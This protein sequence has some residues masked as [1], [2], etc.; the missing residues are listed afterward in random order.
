MTKRKIPIDSLSESTHPSSQAEWDST[1]NAHDRFKGLLASSP[2]AMA[3]YNTATAEIEARMVTL[4]NLRKAQSLTQ[5][6][7]AELL[8]MDQSEV[9]RLENRTD[10]LL[11]TLRR[12][13]EAT[14]GQLDLVARYPGSEPVAI[15][16]GD[17]K[18]A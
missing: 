16:F 2:T 4:K 12:F 9:S 10:L 18:A 13:V 15:K 14:G 7:M 11:S 1:D 5:A 8:G 17:A 3:R 6:T